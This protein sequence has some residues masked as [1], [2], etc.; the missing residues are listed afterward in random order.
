MPA[1]KRHAYRADFKLKAIE[2]A[3]EHGN[4]AAAR[5]FRVNESM[6]RKWR[7]VQESL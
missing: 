7:K 6:V 1:A 4:L 3:K 5:E 2:Y